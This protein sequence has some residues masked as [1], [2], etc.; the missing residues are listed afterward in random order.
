MDSTTNFAPASGAAVFPL[1][2]RGTSGERVGE[3]FYCSASYGFHS[4]LSEVCH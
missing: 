3:G 1:S 4:K 2:S